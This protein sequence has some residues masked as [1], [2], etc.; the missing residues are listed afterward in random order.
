M[1]KRFGVRAICIAAGAA[2]CAGPPA[3]YGPCRFDTASMSFAGDAQAQARCLLRPVGVWKELG[4]VH[5]RLPEVLERTVDAPLPLGKAAFRAYL[6]RQGL[7][8]SELGGSLDSR[9]SRSQDDALWGAPARYFVLHDTSAPYFGAAPFPVALD[10]DPRVNR[11]DGYRSAEPVAHVFINRR[12]EVYLGHDFLEPWR[13]TKLELN[14][15]VGEPAKGLFL[16]VELVQPRRRHPDGDPDNDALAP[17]PGF[18]R[19]QYRR[20][21]E[22]YLAASLRAD[23]GLIPA[24]HAVLDKGFEDGHDDPQNFD[25]GAWAAEIEAVLREAGP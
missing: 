1:S 3:V 22:L 21:A 23:R 11:L 13:A 9:L 8:E 18:S 7:S 25:L 10:R 5:D 24:F 2:A 12:G 6:A 15:H 19:L 17:D 16:H 4:P 14:R 20:L